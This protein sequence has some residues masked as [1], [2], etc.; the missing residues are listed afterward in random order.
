MSS[1]MHVAGQLTAL[2]WTMFALYLVAALLSFRAAVSVRSHSSAVSRQQSSE[3]SR[4]WIWLG[5]V[6]TALGLNKQLDLQTRLIEFGRYLAH[7]A[8]L[9]PFLPGLHVLFFLGFVLAITMLFAVAMLRLRAVIGTF[10][11]QLP[12]A[13][14]GCALICTYILIR[15]ASIDSVD[16]MLGYDWDT[17][18]FLWLLEAGGL[19]LII[20]QAF[21]NPK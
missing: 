1:D 16:R 21:R 19:L 3:T 10:G 8:N 7:Q 15:A 13:A 12:L 14:G 17:I 11:R 6:L 18:P 9:L 20:A 4:I 5:A 2:G